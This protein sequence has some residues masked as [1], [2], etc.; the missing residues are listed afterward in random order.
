MAGTHA[1][2]CVAG[3]QHEVAATSASI[4]VSSHWKEALT[5]TLKAE[6]LWPFMSA[7]ME[8]PCA[9][10]FFTPPISESDLKWG[11]QMVRV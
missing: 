8:A 2:H 11:H 4:T 9:T 6:V 10:S 5:T 1:E 3:T 7:H